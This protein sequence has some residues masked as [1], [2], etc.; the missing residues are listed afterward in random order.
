MTPLMSR[1]LW[2]RHAAQAASSRLTSR[3]AVKLFV[4][5]G[6]VDTW[7]CDS[8]AA[9]SAVVTCFIFVAPLFLIFAQ[10]NLRS[11]FYRKLII[12]CAFSFIL[13]FF[14][15][16]RFE[17]REEPSRIHAIWRCCYCEVHTSN[18][19]HLVSDQLLFIEAYSSFHFCFSAAAYVL[20]TTT[21]D[22][23][24][25]QLLWPLHIKNIQSLLPRQLLFPQSTKFASLGQLPNK[26]E[27][28]AW[29]EIYGN[30]SVQIPQLFIVEFE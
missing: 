13:P 3:Q 9:A 17:K 11:L 20:F 25:I 2:F 30:C 21:A 6:Q 23:Y 27:I 16:W 4:P 18:G 1:Y 15:R 14:F 29:S 10:F 22:N 12:C 5:P 28:Y 26:Y 24:K 8:G 7:V 19:R